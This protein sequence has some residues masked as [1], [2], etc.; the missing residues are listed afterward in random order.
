MGIHP[1]LRWV[2]LGPDF[3]I[4]RLIAVSIILSKVLQSAFFTVS[5][6]GIS[7]LIIMLVQMVLDA[8]SLEQTVLRL[9][10]ERAASMGQ[11]RLPQLVRWR[12]CKVPLGRSLSVAPFCKVARESC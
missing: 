4:L 6:R 3:T 12:G 10:R 9:M 7:G 1:E 2:T 8:G 11:T 5:P